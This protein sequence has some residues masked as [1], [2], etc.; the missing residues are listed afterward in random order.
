MG[1]K[2]SLILLTGKWQESVSVGGQCSMGGSHGA[3]RCNKTGSMVRLVL[4]PLAVV[5]WST[6]EYPNG[7][8]LYKFEV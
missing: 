7:G 6:E 3:R 4:S 2:Y 8:A 1:T 5:L